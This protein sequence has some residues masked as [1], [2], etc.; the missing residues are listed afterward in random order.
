[1]SYNAAGKTDHWFQ[2]DFWILFVGVKLF[3][4]YHHISEKN[5]RKATKKITITKHTDN[6]D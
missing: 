3:G 2:C 1:M 5:S 4:K 6:Q